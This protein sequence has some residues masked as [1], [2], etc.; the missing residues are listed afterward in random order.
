M[1]GVSLVG[2]R[3]SGANLTAVLLP[4]RRSWAFATTGALEGR[5]AV[6]TDGELLASLSEQQLVNC[7]TGGFNKGCRGGHFIY[8]L[9]YTAEKP[10]VTSA[11]YPYARAEGSCSSAG[12]VGYAVNDEGSSYVRVGRTEADFME[13]LEAVGPLAV[14]IRASSDVFRFY[15]SG[16][17]DT[18]EC[19]GVGS[20]VD[21][22]VLLVG[23]GTDDASGADYWILKNSQVAIRGRAGRPSSA[24][25]LSAL[26][27]GAR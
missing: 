4:S 8:A 16:V 17:I 6:E 22:A 15:R 27:A 19:M 5:L 13:A 21:H 1:R 9:R 18:E 7:D 3:F 24:A 23:Y 11:D 26:L 10:A 2:H 25:P 14:A 12:L 20:S